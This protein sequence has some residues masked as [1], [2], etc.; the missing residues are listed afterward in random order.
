MKHYQVENVFLYTSRHFPPCS[1]SEKQCFVRWLSCLQ[2]LSSLNNY[3]ET[4]NCSDQ[5]N[6]H[7]LVNVLFQIVLLLRLMSV[8]NI[9][10]L[11]MSMFTIHV[12][13]HLIPI[14]KSSSFWDN[15]LVYSTSLVSNKNLGSN[16]CSVD[17]NFHLLVNLLSPI[18]LLFTLMSVWN[19]IQFR[20]SIFTLHFIFPL[21]VFRKAVLCAITFL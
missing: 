10:Q 2:Y 1:Y 19:I 13:F 5:N 4:N 3:L 6:F 8:W 9:I 14:R 12:I 21:F 15:C 17:N 20:M 7:Y 18:A 16:N 11:I